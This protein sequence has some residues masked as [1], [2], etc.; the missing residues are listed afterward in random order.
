M[1]AVQAVYKSFFQI[2]AMN[3]AGC[4]VHN[5]RVNEDQRPGSAQ[6]CDTGIHAG[7]LRDKED[8][9][10]GSVGSRVVRRP[11]RSRQLTRRRVHLIASANPLG[12]DLPRFGFHRAD[13]YLDFVR[14]NLPAPLRL[15]CTQRLL[16]AVEQPLAGGRQDDA[17]RIR[18]LQQAL[19]DPSTVAIVAASGG[20]YFSRIL[21]HLDFSALRRRSQPLTVFGFSELTGLV[22]LAASCRG[23]RGVYWLCPN[24]LAW[25]LRPLAAARAAFAEFWERLPWLVARLS[26]PRGASRNQV[27]S[28]VNGDVSNPGADQTAHRQA[29]LR[30][31]HAIEGELAAGRTRSGTIR[32]VGGC[33]SV[34]AA[35]IGGP[36]GRR[37]RAEDRWLAL[38]DI[39]EAPYRID[40]YLAALKLA[41]WFE[42]IGGVLVGDFHTKQERDQRAVVVELL[43]FHLPP[44]RRVPIVTTRS[45]GHVW[46]MAPLPLNRPVLMRVSGRHVTI[47]AVPG[48]RVDQRPALR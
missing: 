17:Q 32:V 16:E 25:K 29:A 20:G 44:D 26:G 2:R 19:D 11:M 8:Q 1:A 6:A 37:I 30:Y 48:T 13:E 34:L 12:P 42:R 7:G 41:G 24:F 35:V 40:R 9:R 45:F 27:H 36:L 10:P 43:R 18:D 46:P 4:G 39:S 21:P 28:H 23:A 3:A 33:L 5:P 15:T 22:N 47:R 38:E 14:K 31:P